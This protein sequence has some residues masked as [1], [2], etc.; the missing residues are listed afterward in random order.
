MNKSDLIKS[1]SDSTGVKN[2]EATRLVDAV[3]DTIT[4][5]L[6][7]AQI[8]G[9]VAIG[10]RDSSAPTTSKEGF[11]VVAPINTTSPDSTAGKSASCC[12]LL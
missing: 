5:N 12:D 4:S 6:K 9:S 1:I 10:G 8:A 2:T 11:S 7:R 3:F